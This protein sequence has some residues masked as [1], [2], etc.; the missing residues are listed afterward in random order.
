MPP[1]TAPA[2]APARLI[3]LDAFRGCVIVT[4]IWVNYLAGMPN[5]AFW[6]EHA[7]PR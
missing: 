2:P 4:M 7:G 6:L 5:I 1:A 3:S